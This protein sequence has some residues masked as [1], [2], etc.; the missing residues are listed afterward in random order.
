NLRNMHTNLLRSYGGFY[1]LAIKT[2]LNRYALN[3]GY[4][5]TYSNVRASAREEKTIRWFVLSPLYGE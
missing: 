5:P 3:N 2:F 1:R 4:K